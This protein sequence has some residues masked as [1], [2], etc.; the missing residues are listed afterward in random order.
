V[1][2]ATGQAE[3]HPSL[4]PLND[5]GL[6]GVVPVTP[7]SGQLTPADQG[8]VLD[9]IAMF[10]EQAAAGT[11]DC[12]AAMHAGMAAEDGRRQHYGQ[13][14][15]PAGSSYGDA[16]DLP[17]VPDNAVPPASSDL[18]PWPGQEPTP[19]AAGTDF[20]TTGDEPK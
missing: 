20:Y 11:A 17:P 3:D 19:A 16:M 5:A 18:Y 9:T 10:G 15:L 4:L 14:I 8:G 1:E 2:I 13:A 7:V 6:P 12:A